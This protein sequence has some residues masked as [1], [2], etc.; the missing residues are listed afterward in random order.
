MLHNEPIVQKEDKKILYE[1]QKK[2]IDAI[3]D[4]MDNT[5]PNYHLLYQLPRSEER[6]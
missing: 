2:D 1:Y 5:P 4:R 6:V 3:F